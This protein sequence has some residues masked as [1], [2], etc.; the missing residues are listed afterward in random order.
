MVSATTKNVSIHILYHEQQH[1]IWNDFCAIGS[2]S[3]TLSLFFTSDQLIIL[4]TC[5]IAESSLLVGLDHLFINLQVTVLL[6]CVYRSGKLF[7]LMVKLLIFACLYKEEVFNFQQNY[8]FV[9][10]GLQTSLLCL[11]ALQRMAF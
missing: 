5:L 3:F 11:E 8:A 4:F 10:S 7:W 9:S 1:G 6:S 2:F